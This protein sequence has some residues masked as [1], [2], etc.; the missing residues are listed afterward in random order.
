MDEKEVQEKTL[1]L[2]KRIVN[3]LKPE[4][5]CIS[6]EVVICDVCGAANDKKSGFCKKCSNILFKKK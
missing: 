2:T 6:T 3:S 4:D 1:D 5:L